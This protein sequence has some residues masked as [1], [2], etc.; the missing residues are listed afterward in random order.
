[1][2]RTT[3]EILAI[4][5]ELLRWE[6]QDTNT[7]WICRLINSRGGE[8]VRSTM[9]PDIEEEI[10][11]AVRAAVDRR[12]DILFTSGGLGPTEDDLTLAAVAKGAGVDLALDTT[13]R[14]MVRQRYDDF[15]AQGVL[16]Q[17]GLNLF[18]EKMAW[19]PVG[20][21]PLHNPVGTA[22]GVMLQVETTTIISLPGV[23]PE[24][25][26]IITQSLATFIDQTFGSGS[27]CSRTLT[28]RCNDESIMAPAL[29]QVIAHHPQVYIKSLARVL[30]EVPELDILFTTTNAQAALAQAQV[31][32]AYSELAERLSALGI[33][34]WAKCGGE[35]KA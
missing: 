17:G 9:L 12:V 26:G 30:G 29:R 14:D 18:R 1:M 22:P 3:V 32:A 16:A 28:V 7:T 19:L 10:A 6:I 11:A 34:H 35:P 21:T 4:G 24:L 33:D 31:M 20:A 27:A 15:H 13:A 5:N 8:V 25:E 2:L 23:P